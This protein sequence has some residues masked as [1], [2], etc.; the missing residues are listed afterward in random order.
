MSDFSLNLNSLVDSLT[1]YPSVLYGPRVDNAS[2]N[3][4]NWFDRNSVGKD[5]VSTITNADGTTSTNTT[6]G[7]FFNSNIAKGAQGLYSVGMDLRNAFMD[8]QRLSMAKDQMNKQYDL[9]LKKYGLSNAAFSN[10]VAAQNAHYNT[11]V[12][13]GLAK[14]RPSDTPMYKTS[15]KIS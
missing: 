4:G 6:P 10:N 3:K 5:T 8:N 13:A 15:Y 2:N 14:K 1:K 7:S 12:D 11:L 9:G